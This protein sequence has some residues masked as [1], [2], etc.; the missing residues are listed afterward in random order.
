MSKPVT[1]TEFGQLRNRA[2]ILQDQRINHAKREY[3]RTLVTIAR[4]EH[5]MTVTHASRRK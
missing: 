2:H 1:Y 3:E 4:L 5:D